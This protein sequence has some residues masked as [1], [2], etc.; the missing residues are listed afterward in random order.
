MIDGVLRDGKVDSDLLGVKDGIIDGSVLSDNS[1]QDL[2]SAL[3]K[4]LSFIVHISVK[5]C[6]LANK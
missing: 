5:N 6:S 2:G 3:L 4:L 1:D